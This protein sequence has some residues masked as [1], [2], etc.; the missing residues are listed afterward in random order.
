MCEDDTA[1]S[2]CQDPWKQ[3]FER[4]DYWLEENP[5]YYNS[6][7]WET[8]REK[9]LGI[10]CYWATGP[11]TRSCDFTEHISYFDAYYWTPYFRDVYAV[12]FEEIGGTETFTF[13]EYEFT[14]NGWK[15]QLQEYYDEYDYYWGEGLDLEDYV[16]C[17]DQYPNSV[18]LCYNISLYYKNLDHY[19]DNYYEHYSQ[20]EAF[21]WYLD[22]NDDTEIV[23]KYSDFLYFDKEIKNIITLYDNIGQD[24]TWT[25]GSE[26]L[27]VGPNFPHVHSTLYA[28]TRWESLADDI[29]IIGIN[30]K[31]DWSFHDWYLDKLQLLANKLDKDTF[32]IGY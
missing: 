10:C 22:D 17:L 30:T 31:N 18:E 28:L 26:V 14:W 3:T 2:C 15:N 19:V 27:R 13:Q 9:D 6:V 8:L 24:N 1:N 23:D 5:N 32:V 29:D 25:W 4:T 20:W 11:T 7:E 12:Y 21:E 16:N